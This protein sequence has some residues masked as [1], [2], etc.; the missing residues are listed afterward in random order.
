MILKVTATG[1]RVRVM[2]TNT[3]HGQRFLLVDTE[4]GEAE[5]PVNEFWLDNQI[6]EGIFRQETTR[7]RTKREK[8]VKRN[9]R[10]GDRYRCALT[11]KLF[12]IERIETLHGERWLLR[13]VESGNP[14]T[15]KLAAYII[16]QIEDGQLVKARRTETA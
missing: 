5:G 10:N 8:A 16:N 6:V 11:R 12:D 3:I 4:T 2:K 14:G 1:Q 7:E 9:F 15:P 13:S